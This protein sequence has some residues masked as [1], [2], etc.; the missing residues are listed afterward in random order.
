MVK[1][2]Y[3]DYSPLTKKLEED[4]YLNELVSNSFNTE[5]WDVS[6]L[7]F[8]DLKLPDMVNRNYVRRFDNFKKF[9][10]AIS[11]ED[12][13]NTVFI[14]LI[15][16]GWPSIKLYEV[17]TKY[18]CK[19]FSYCASV[20]LSYSGLTFERI[21]SN[22]NFGFFKKIFRYLLR[23]LS[24]LCLRFG[25]IKYPDTVFVMGSRFVSLQ[26]RSS[27]VIHINS[28]DYDRYMLVRNK[29]E[30]LVTYKYC[31]FLD[32]YLI[33]HPDLKLLNIKPADP[34]EYYNRLN[35]FFD[36]IEKRFSLKVIIAAHPKSDY[37]DN[38]FGGRQ[39]Y[40]SKTNELVKDCEFA[41]TTLSTAINYPVLYKKP[42]ILFFTDGL[43]K[44]YSIFSCRAY[45]IRMAKELDCPVYNINRIRDEDIVI[46]DPDVKKYD[47]WKYNYLT[48][49]ES[50]S[51]SSKDIVIDYLKNFKVTGS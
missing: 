51:K 32:D 6:N 2:I 46:K 29:T 35:E 24:I 5:Y 9:Y 39:I 20:P 19:I 16:Y 42:I 43:A 12:I 38:C 48:S 33:D 21:L 13:E 26:E 14:P 3:I 37:K 50:G 30:K 41:I 31:V 25:I 34:A 8:H 28:A 4:F 7:Y 27:R 18:K 10:D 49:R 45:V 23:K 36:A 44:K 47:D 22:L 17:L 40:R 11:A 15:T 1:I